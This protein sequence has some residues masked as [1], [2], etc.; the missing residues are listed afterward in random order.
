MGGALGSLSVADFSVLLVWSFE[1]KVDGRNILGGL[2]SESVSLIA[3]VVELVLAWF[4]PAHVFWML[5]SYN[6]D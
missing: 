2:E 3:V 4:Q 1:C 6:H 5:R